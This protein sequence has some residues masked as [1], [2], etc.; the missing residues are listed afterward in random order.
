MQRCSSRPIPPLQIPNTAD[1]TGPLGDKHSYAMWSATEEKRF[2]NRRAFRR[3]FRPMGVR[4]WSILSPRD[5]LALWM[6]EEPFHHE[7]PRCEPAPIRTLPSSRACFTALPIRLCQVTIQGVD[8]WSSP[9]R[10][11][12]GRA[13]MPLVSIGPS[14]WNAVCI[15]PT[16]KGTSMRKIQTILSEFA[17]IYIDSAMESRRTRPPAHIVITRGGRDDGGS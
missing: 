11:L 2:C 5:M 12:T 7:R 9:Q 14:D 8:R 13:S 1:S 4:S 15:C 10:F 6:L 3:Q 17:G 16:R